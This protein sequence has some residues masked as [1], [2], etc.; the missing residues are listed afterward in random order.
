MTFKRRGGRKEL[1]VPHTYE[2]TAG[3]DS[4]SA[5]ASLNKPLAIAVALGHRWLKLLMAGKFASVSELA[6]ALRM[7]PS[8]VRRNINLTLL[9]PRLVQQI[10]DGD[11]P[12]GAALQ[13]L[14]H[15][16]PAVWEKQ[17]GGR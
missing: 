6:E 5:P 4:A 8:N 15:D 2:P 9:A 13:R 3:D 10:L 17:Q 11:E 14:Y 16:V 1:I 12:D 7:H